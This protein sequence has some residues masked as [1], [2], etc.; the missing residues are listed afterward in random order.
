MKR[1]SIIALGINIICAL[2]TSCTSPERSPEDTSNSDLY[3]TNFKMGFSKSSGPLLNTFFTFKL[4][5]TIPPMLLTAHHVVAV[6]GRGD[7]FYRWNELTGKLSHAWLWSIHD[8]R[9]QTGLGDNIP[10]PN[11]MT[12][13]IDLAAYQLPDDQRELP[14]LRPS[15]TAANVGDSVILFSK[16]KVRD[17][18]SLLTPGI[19]IYATD[20]LIIY[21]LQ[22]D[23]LIQMAGTSGSPVLD[24]KHRVVSNSFGAFSIPD[25]TL[26]ETQLAPMFPLI[27]KL[28]VRQGKTYGIGVPIQLISQSLYKALGDK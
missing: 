7:E 9:L 17:H 4:H 20:S 19:I 10:V 24:L 8:D 13:Q 6:K 3:G 15:E 21:E 26:I 16:L 23:T 11:A 25:S 14:Y 12:M 2:L 22:C 27:R 28:R 18:Y 5:D 1:L